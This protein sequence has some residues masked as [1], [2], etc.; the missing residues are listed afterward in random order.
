MLNITIRGKKRTLW[1]VIRRIWNI[2]WNRLVN[3]VV[4]IEHILRGIGYNVELYRTEQIAY[5]VNLGLDFIEAERELERIYSEYPELTESSHH[6]LLMVALRKKYNFRSILEIGTDKGKG[7]FLLSILFPESQITTIDLQDDS[8][9]FLSAYGRGTYEQSKNFLADRNNRLACRHNIEFVPMNSVRLSIVKNKKYDFIW[10]D[11][12]HNYPVVAIDIAN[13]LR[14]LK[15]DGF[16]GIDDV[17][18]TGKNKNIYQSIAAYETL[19]IFKKEGLIEMY[20][21]LKRLKKP[22]ARNKL[23]KYIVVAKKSRNH[24]ML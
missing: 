5:F 22:Y 2:L 17:Y 7:A 21:I 12:A 23:R 18:T 14:L 20:F 10:V 9:Q 6:H 15:N 3:K 19:N 11:G 24:I 13:C 1:E 8:D 16:L 4:K